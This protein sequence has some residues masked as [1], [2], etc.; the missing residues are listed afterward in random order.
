MDHAALMGVA[1][2]AAD[3]LEQRQP[4]PQSGL[5]SVTRR[6][7]KGFR[8]TLKHLGS[9]GTAAQ[10]QHGKCM[11]RSPDEFALPTL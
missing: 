8:F 7:R 4:E 10:R 9:L 11:K 2:G 3:L 1:Y 6:S 5:G